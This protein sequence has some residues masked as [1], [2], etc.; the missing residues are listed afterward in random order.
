[1]Q[2]QAVAEVELEFDPRSL[3]GGRV[4]RSQ[5]DEGRCSAADYGFATFAVVV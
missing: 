5:F 2:A 1:M 3:W 4:Q